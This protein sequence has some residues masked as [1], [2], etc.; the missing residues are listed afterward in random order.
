[1]RF[2]QGLY[3]SLMLIYVLTTLLLASAPHRDLADWIAYGGNLAL[4]CIGIVGVIAAFCTLSFVKSQIVEMR[5]QRIL[6]NKTLM[7]IERQTAATEKQARHMVESER[8]FLM[9]E[10][11][12]NVDHMALKVTNK[13]RSPAKVLYLDPFIL[14]KTVPLGDDLESPPDYGPGY[15][16]C[17]AGAE[18]VNPEWIEPEGHTFAGFYRARTELA[19]FPK[20][21]DE[22]KSGSVIL[23]VYGVVVY[24]GL[25]GD[26]T[27][28]SIYCYRLG[29]GNWSMLGPYG[30]N[31]Y[32]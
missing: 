15:M 26:D 3:I 32:T 20:M 4:V 1:M 11:I 29:S 21:Q 2:Q 28:E 17:K 24:K 13:G 16:N 7:K 14:P 9:I 19:L 18:L 8:P 27:Y 25:F 5:K 31:E 6:M 23:W 12:G 10:A 30:Y 22:V